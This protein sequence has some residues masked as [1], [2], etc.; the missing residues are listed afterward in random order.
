MPKM[1]LADRS[2]LGD[3]V[4]VTTLVVRNL[5]RGCAFFV[6]PSDGMGL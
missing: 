5:P 1:V 4:I 6:Q 2:G 3:A